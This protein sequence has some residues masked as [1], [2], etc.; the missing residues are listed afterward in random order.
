[1]SIPGFGVALRHAPQ[2]PSQTPTRTIAQTTG[3]GVG[4]QVGNA[5]GELQTNYAG[6]LTVDQKTKINALSEKL[7]AALARGDKAAATKLEQDSKDFLDQPGVRAALSKQVEAGIKAQGGNDPSFM[8]KYGDLM[9]L[10]AKAL[11]EGLHNKQSDAYWEK[12]GVA[13]KGLAT[14]Q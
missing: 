14:S 5:N 11:I 9:M 4:N 12:L 7:V 8:S 13:L 10:L 2:I 6:G 1:M 3:Q